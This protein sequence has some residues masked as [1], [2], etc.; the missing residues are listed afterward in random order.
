ML[1]PKQVEKVVQ[2]LKLAEQRRTTADP[3]LAARLLGDRLAVDGLFREPRPAWAS[4][5]ESVGLVEAGLAALAGLFT[6]LD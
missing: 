2:E 6:S 5:L 1:D 4:G 3:L